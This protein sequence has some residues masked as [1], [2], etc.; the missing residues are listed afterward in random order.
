MQELRETRVR[1]NGQDTILLDA[2][3]VISSVSGGSF[4][5]AYYGLYGERLFEDFEERCL[6]RDVE[7]A[8]LR[9][10]LNPLR[11][12]SSRGRTDMAVA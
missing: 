5:S 9:G 11:R 12:F 7:G 6:R 4:T 3:S 2:I 1:L 8:L 10:F